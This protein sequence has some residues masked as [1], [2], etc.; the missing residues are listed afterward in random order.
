MVES[1][2]ILK[3]KNPRRTALMSFLGQIPKLMTTND[4]LFDQISQ[5]NFSEKKHKSPIR[6]TIRWAIS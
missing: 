2:L 4:A 3:R 1:L 6:S 5:S